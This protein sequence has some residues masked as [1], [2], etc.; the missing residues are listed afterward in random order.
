MSRR[1]RALTRAILAAAAIGG[2]IAVLPATAQAAQ[3]KPGFY[4]CWGYGGTF[5]YYGTYEFKTP[6]QYLFAA[7]RKGH[8][9]LGKVDKGD[10]RL[11]GKKLTPTSGPMKSN[12]LY[13]VEKNANE[14]ILANPNHLAI[15]C[16][17]KGH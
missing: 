4:D 5:T 8:R 16:Y 7:D 9:L 13:M 3:I 1:T 17:F 2:P 10:Y 6:G 14:W 11:H 15:A 12:H